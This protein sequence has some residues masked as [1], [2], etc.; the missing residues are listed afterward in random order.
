M[1]ERSQRAGIPIAKVDL[2]TIEP[3]DRFEAWHDTMRPV[4]DA[5]PI[6]APQSFQGRM[7]VARPADLMLFRGAYT[8]QICTRTSR[9][10]D[11]SDHFQLVFYQRG[12]LAG[13]RTGTPF[14]VIPDRIALCDFGRPHDAVVSAPSELM[15]AAIPR[16][17]IDVSK[18]ADR[19]TICWSTNSAAGRL[20][21][22][23]LQTLWEVVDLQLEDEAAESTAGLTGLI[24]GVL[25]ARRQ[26]QDPRLVGRVCLS[27]IQRY[28]N[29][30]LHRPDLK[31]TTIGRVFGCSRSQLYR[32]FREFGGVDTYIR[33]RRLDRCCLELA[34]ATH[35]PLR[36]GPIAERWGFRDPSHFHRLFKQRFGVR[37]SDVL[38]SGAHPGGH[39]GD[40]RNRVA[41]NI[42]TWIR[43]L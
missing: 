29:D 14:Q 7:D 23:A 11:D 19:P 13:S 43:A 35:R 25:G 39:N 26:R 20:L 33:Q 42:D 1:A 36:V 8:P 4:Y 32:L 5:G 34:A 16:S 28:I 21:V 12:G 40:T 38:A 31:A 9:H 18:V 17:Y 3:R 30:H 24:N 2:E 6:G 37:P 27:T 41:D 22:G 15:V 10:A